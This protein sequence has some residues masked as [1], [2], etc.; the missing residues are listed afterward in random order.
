MGRL[1]FHT[2]RPVSV[3]D[4][5]SGSGRSR[6]MEDRLN[7]GSLELKKSRTMTEDPTVVTDDNERGPHGEIVHVDVDHGSYEV[8]KTHHHCLNDYLEVDSLLP[9]RRRNSRD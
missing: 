2:R 3:D 5:W 1:W 7:V 6:G 8:E 4:G 9:K